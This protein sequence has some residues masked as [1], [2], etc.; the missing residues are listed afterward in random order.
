MM[1]TVPCCARHP[2]VLWLADNNISSLKGLRS[3]CKLRELNLARNDI[4]VRGRSNVGTQQ[5]RCS[6]PVYVC[7]FACVCACVCVCVCVCVRVCGCV[8]A[9]MQ[10]GGCSKRVCVFASAAGQVLHTC[11]CVCVHVCVCACVCVCMCVCAGN[12]IQEHCSAP[13]ALGRALPYPG[14]MMPRPAWM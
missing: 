4:Q 11:V 10:Q 1:K 12:D 3:L 7:V 9:C 14:L 8:C 13:M 2:Q 6:I 5:G